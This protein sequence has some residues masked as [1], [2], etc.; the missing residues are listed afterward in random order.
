MLM[1]RAQDDRRKFPRFLVDWQASIRMGEKEIYHDRIYDISL[2][3]AGI[4]AGRNI[5]T[6]NPLVILIDTPLPHFRQKKVPARIE[7]SMCHTVLASDQDKFYI[8]V[9]FLHFRGIE[10]YLLAEALF[11]L[12]VL[13]T[14]RAH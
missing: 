5:L 10:K 2:G 14:R 4:C 6:G 9:Q 3:G 1:E 11:S 7:C 8:G 12:P 13:P